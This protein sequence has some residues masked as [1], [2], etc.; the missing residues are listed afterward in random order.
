MARDVE[1]LQLQMSADLRRFEKS[2]NSMRATAD[3]RLNEV[4]RRAMASQKNLSRI[5]DDAGKGMVS[6]LRSGLA[7]IAPTLAAAFSAQQVVKY[8]DAYTQLQNRLRAAGLEGRDLQKV[9]DALYETANRNGLQV[10]ATAEL[11]ARASLSRQRLGAS[12]AQ[13]LQLVSGT[14]AAL[15]VQGTSAEAASGP[16]LQLGQALSG[17]KVQAEEYNSLIDGLPVLLQAAAKGSSRFGGDVAKLTEQVKAGKV[18]SQEFFQALLAGFPAIEAQAGT[19]TATVSS[20]L[21]T[22]DNQL[23]RYIGQADSSLSA[24]QRMAQGIVLLA[25]NLDVVTNVV[26]G[27]A[28]VIGGRYLLS[29][30]ASASATL[31]ATVSSVRY[32]MALVSLEARQLGVTRATVLATGATRSFSAAVA[33]NP[34][35]A[36][37]LAVTAL[38]AGIYLLNQRFSEGARAAREFEQMTTSGTQALAEYEKAQAAAQSAS[39]E[40]AAYARENAAAM[41]EEAQAAIVAAR[42]LAAK[43]TQEAQTRLSAATAAVQEVNKGRPGE[44]GEALGQLAYAA[45]AMRESARA[46]DQAAAAIR[47]QIRQEQ[48]FA[49]ISSGINLGGTGT[50]A[51]TDDK[52]TGNAKGASGPTPVELAA[53]R[54]LLTIQREIELLR[55][56]GNDDAARTKQRELDVM[57]MTKQLTDAGAMDAKA[58]AE[59]H[60]RAIATAEDAQRGLEILW[61][62]NEEALDAQIA[63]TERS[64]D[65]LMDRLGFEAEL[66]RLAGQ[67]GRADAAE[68]ELFIAGRVNELLERKIELTRADAEARAGREW[69]ALDSADT[70]GRMRDEFRRSFSEGIRAA[71][72]GDLGGFFESMADRFTDRMLENLADD[73]FDLLGQAAKGFASSNGGGSGWM[74]AIAGLFAGKR[75]TGGGVVGGQAYITGERRPEVFVPHTSGTIIPSVN[76]AMNRAQQAQGMRSQPVIVQLS[77]EEGAMFAP[78]VQA[79]SGRVSVQTTAAG[80]AYAQD[81]TQQSARRQRQRLV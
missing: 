60:V 81:Q 78:K 75:A 32:Q 37:L 41:R 6:S 7:S 39:K 4:E 19:A 79:I 10:Q 52:K 55:A 47:E 49:R 9:E 1:S 68:R 72:D 77:V 71:I 45:G 43:R 76:A 57:N 29:L 35:G 8:A 12:E 54:E 74:T 22:L 64:N 33:A 36:A 51:V 73:L 66:A 69:S 38:A 50:T 59:A 23:G 31:A 46:R 2:M 40:S 26:G 15:K 3:K 5:M 30:T 24:T 17:T 63:A 16:L 13:L 62:R 42:A 67:E 61:E 14:A 11:Y 25:N 58:T 44:P 53:Q 70:E 65:L 18:S 80:V 28:A 56:Q 21:Q 48:E 34:I 20:A 27:L